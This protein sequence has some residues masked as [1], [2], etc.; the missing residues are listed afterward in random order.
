MLVVVGVMLLALPWV[1]LMLYGLVGI[2][3]R[4]RE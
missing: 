1:V 4:C 2:L 3:A